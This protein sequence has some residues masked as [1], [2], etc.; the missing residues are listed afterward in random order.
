MKTSDDSRIKKHFSLFKILNLVCY[1]MQLY[2]N[3]IAVEY[4]KKYILS[5]KK[6]SK[7]ISI[8]GKFR[9]NYHHCVELPE[10]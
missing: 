2:T 3:K 5:Q 10:K 8:F 6:T 9:S 7:L 1:L 4:N